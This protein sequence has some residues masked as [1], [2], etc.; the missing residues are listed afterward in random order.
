MAR[1]GNGVSKGAI[2]SALGITSAFLATVEAFV[3]DPLG[4]GLER[5]RPWIVDQIFS[6]WEMVL[7]YVESAWSALAAIPRIAIYEP[8]TAAFGP[9]G[10]AIQGV[11]RDVGDIAVDVSEAA[12]PFAPI[13]VVAIW[14]VPALLGVSAVYFLV[15]LV[16]TYLP[17]KGIPVIRRIA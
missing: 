10:T 12:G 8:L 11:W 16:S 5:L 17:L 6:L 15:G 13:V 2:L 7:V 14:L 3:E 4:F 9:A 1:D